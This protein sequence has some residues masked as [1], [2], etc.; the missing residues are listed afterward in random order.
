MPQLD[1]IQETKEPS[2]GGGVEPDYHALGGNGAAAQGADIARPRSRFSGMFVKK[3]R[4][5]SLGPGDPPRKLKKA[6]G[7]F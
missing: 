5:P 6:R 7:V 2:I 4:S 1:Q 3:E